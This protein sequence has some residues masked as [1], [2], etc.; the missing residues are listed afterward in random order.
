MA[1]GAGKG[2]KAVLSYLAKAEAAWRTADEVAEALGVVHGTAWVLLERCRLF[3]NLR[4]RKEGGK[5]Y[6]QVTE[7]GKKLVK[8][9]F[10]RGKG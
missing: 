5:R 6:Y 8:A 10:E 2:W 7:K 1:R 4:S 3:S 9:G